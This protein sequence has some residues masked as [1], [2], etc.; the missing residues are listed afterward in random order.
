MRAEAPSLP[1]KASS[2]RC[3]VH[4]PFR[5]PRSL[6]VRVMGAGGRVVS[7]A[8]MVIGDGTDASVLRHDTK[9]MDLREL[10]RE[11]L[12]PGPHTQIVL[13]HWGVPLEDGPLLTPDEEAELRVL[14]ARQKMLGDGSGSSD[15]ADDER[16]EA[17][18][19]AARIAGLKRRHTLAAVGIRDDACVCA[20]LVD[21]RPPPLAPGAWPS[22]VRVLG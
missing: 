14:E 12:L 1:P 11:Q 8:D 3:D 18:E 10:V 5:Y 13:E 15:L 4:L 20:R 16:E 21:R 22:R 6:V 9:V 17:A 7:V 19:I 2:W